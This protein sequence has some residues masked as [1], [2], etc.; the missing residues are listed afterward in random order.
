MSIEL[1]KYPIGRFKRPKDVNPVMLKSW[2]E[3]IEFFPK[4]VRVAVTPL[5]EEAL[6]WQYR[7]DGWTIKQVVHH[8]ADSHMNS[9]I[10]FKLA[11]TEKE[12]TIKPYQEAKWGDLP[13]TIQAPIAGSLNL[14]DGLH[15]RWTILLKSLTE[16]DLK[17]T[18]IHPEYNRALQLMENI[19]LYAWHCNHHLSHIQQAKRWKNDFSSFA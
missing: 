14:L 8:C 18:F 12:P 1:L 19:A 9:F 3:I 13:D 4:Q 17:K 15:Q 11:L 5:N 10:R 7:P 6:N 16:E 2:V